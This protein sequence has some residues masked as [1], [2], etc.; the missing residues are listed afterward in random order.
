VAIKLKSFCNAAVGF[1][2]WLDD[3]CARDF[4]SPINVIRMH[5]YNEPV[6]SYSIRVWIRVDFTRSV[7]PERNVLL[8]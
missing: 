2:D 7:K 3:F 1:I 5:V 6:W 4:A 8:L